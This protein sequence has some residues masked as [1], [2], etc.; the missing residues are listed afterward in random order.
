MNEPRFQHN[1]GDRVKD[2]ISGFSGIVVSR[3]EAIFGCNRYWV[4]PEQMH[5]GKPIDGRWFDEESI[6]VIQAG[7]VVRPTY[8]RVVVAPVEAAAP[9]RRAGGPSN[10]P[11]SHGSG[12]TR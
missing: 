3:S 2:R 1:L 10:Q 5:D 4:E 9:Q 8:A 6:E 11:A 12:S 7:A